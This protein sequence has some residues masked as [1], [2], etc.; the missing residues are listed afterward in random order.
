M[1]LSDRAT[2][3]RRV[4]EWC[5]WHSW[6]AW[7]PVRLGSGDI[8]WLERVERRFKYVRS[9]HEGWWTRRYRK[10]AQRG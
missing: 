8:V 9:W 3:W 4:R 2:G 10:Q 5:T 6:F 1:L 7:F